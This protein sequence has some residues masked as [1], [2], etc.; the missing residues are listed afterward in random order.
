VIDDWAAPEQRAKGTAQQSTSPQ[1]DDGD[2]T[3]AEAARLEEQIA[4]TRERMTETVQAIGDK[5]NPANLVAGAKESVREATIGK[6]EHMANAAGDMINEPIR[7]V[8]DAGT[9][10]V[11]TVRQN[12]IPAAVAAIGL[13]WL[14]RSRSDPAPRW[15]AYGQGF[16]GWSARDVDF[17]PSGQRAGQSG[18]PLEQVGQTL[19]AVATQAGETVGGA[20]SQAGQAVQHVGQELGQRAEGAQGQLGGISRQAQSQFQ[21]LL[22]EN[23]LV[24]G[25]AAVGVGA[26]VATLM[27]TTQVERR[28]YGEPRD[29]LIDQVESVA[30]ETLQGNSDQRGGST[31]NQS[32]WVGQQDR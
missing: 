2:A 28:W 22:D 11:E 8:Q 23:P 14:W 30:H 32:P 24:L 31:A 5:L 1:A 4:E 29:K 27:P 25:A 16:R 18:G 10:L 26:L 20:A 6:V 7:S 3:E 15:Q 13:A 9:G 21:R 17:T 19:G 12:P